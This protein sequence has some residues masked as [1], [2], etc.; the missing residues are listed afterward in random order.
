MAGR[1]LTLEQAIAEALEIVREAQATPTPQS[2]SPAD[3]TARE[4][5]YLFAHEWARTAEDILFRRT[6]LGLH[7]SEQDVSRLTDYL[8]RH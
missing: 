4:V 6:K 8:S 3:L 7:I 1:E 2:T 5:D